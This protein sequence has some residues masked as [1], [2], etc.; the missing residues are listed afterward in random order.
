M[1]PPKKICITQI[2]QGNFLDLTLSQDVKDD[3]LLVPLLGLGNYKSFGFHFQNF[4]FY[5]KE[6]FKKRKERNRVFNLSYY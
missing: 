4:I 5:E 2:S 6:V 3:L 1:K